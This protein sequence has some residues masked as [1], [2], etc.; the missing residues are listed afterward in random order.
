MF[1]PENISEEAAWVRGMAN[2]KQGPVKCFFF[3]FLCLA[4]VAD[5]TPA[6]G[7]VIESCQYCK[8]NEIGIG[9]QWLNSGKVRAG[10]A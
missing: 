3:R 6:G 2:G 9:Y 5:K 1:H 7:P 8:G 4:S 10:A